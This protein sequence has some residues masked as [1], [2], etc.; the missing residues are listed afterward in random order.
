MQD[1]SFPFPPGKAFGLSCVV[2]GGWSLRGAPR[3][4]T[5]L[6]MATVRWWG[7]KRELGEVGSKGHGSRPLTCHP[8][9][10]H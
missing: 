5:F 6:S 3:V 7:R 8:D 2:L 1:P 10:A 9:F 4:L